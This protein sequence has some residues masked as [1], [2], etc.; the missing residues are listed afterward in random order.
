MELLEQQQ[1]AGVSLK[2]DRIDIIVEQALSLNK[3][4]MMM[5]LWHFI[6][7]ELKIRCSDVTYVQEMNLGLT[8]ERKLTVSETSVFKKQRAAC[9]ALS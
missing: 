8:R 9:S 7:C 4:K 1:T 6:S 3:K 5:I 2:G